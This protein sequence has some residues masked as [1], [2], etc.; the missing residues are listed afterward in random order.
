MSIDTSEIIGKSK[1]LKDVFNMLSKV[2]PTETTVLIAGESGTGKELWV[3]ALLDRLAEKRHALI[4]AA[5]TGQLE[6]V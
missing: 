4:T 1:A 5:V 3:R 2:A 6:V